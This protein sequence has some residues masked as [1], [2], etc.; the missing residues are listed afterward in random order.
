MAL[1]AARLDAKPAAAL[2][3]TWDAVARAT[4]KVYLEASGKPERRVSGVAKRP[5]QGSIPP[6]G[7]TSRGRVRR[8]R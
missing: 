2:V 6:V 8:P 1:A 3:P 7:S 5:E 4:L